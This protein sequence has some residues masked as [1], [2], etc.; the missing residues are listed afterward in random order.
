MKR[1]LIL[2]VLSI[3]V[4]LMLAFAAAVA[5]GIHAAQAMN[6][7]GQYFESQGATI[8]YREAGTGMPVIL[9]HG[10][11]VNAGVNFNARGL[12]AELAKQYQVIALDNRGHGRSEKL[13]DP[14]A[15]GTKMCEDIVRLMDHLNIEKAH[16]LGYSMGGF[17][18]LKLATLHP[19]R[20]LSFVIC[21]SGW[22]PEPEKELAFFEEMATTLEQGGNYRALSDRLTPIGKK[23][24]WKNRL[25]MSYGLKLMNDNKAIAAALR[26]MPELSIKAEALQTNTLPALAVVGERD[27]LRPFTEQMA[28][29]TANM[30]IV[31]VP[32]ADHMSL[33]RR[34]KAVDAI[35][36]HLN[37]DTEAL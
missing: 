24:S 35:K 34:E 22:T 29:T 23:V 14:E 6:P 13:Y 5:Y 27:P 7:E 11:A 25:I 19:D 3:A 36:D 28:A 10:L 12:T 9:V 32:D 37:K 4:F 33:L 31:I 1:K 15:Y 26:S 8:H 21:A 17:I 18:V 16:V 20:L 2:G 30:E